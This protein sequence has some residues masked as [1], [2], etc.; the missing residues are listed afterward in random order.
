MLMEAYVV[1]PQDFE[2]DRELVYERVVAGYSLRYFLLTGYFNEC[3]ADEGFPQT[4]LPY[5]G[6]EL[7]KCT[8]SGVFLETAASP[9]VTCDPAEAVR[10]LTVLYNKAV[11]PITFYDVI[12]SIVAF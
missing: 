4:G 12:D 5:Y 6:M 3:F 10:I 1:N 7:E 11:T 2:S 9:G 8:R